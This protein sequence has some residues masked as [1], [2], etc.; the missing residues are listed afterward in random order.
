MNKKNSYLGLSLIIL[1]FAVIFIPRIHDR[2]VN[3]ATIENSRMSN[4]RTNYD[5]TSSR[6]EGDMI[7]ISKVPNFTF[8]N[9]DNDTI[10]QDY[11]KGKVYVVEF[12]FTSCSTICPVMNTNMKLVQEAFKNNDNV[13][14]ASFSID[15]T[16]DRPDVLT[17]YAKSYDVTH[18]NW[19]FLTGK[20]EDI[21]KLSNEGFKLY[22]QEN[23]EA[24]DGF[25]HSG[26]FALVDQEGNVQ[27]RIDENGNP[28][29]YYNGLEIETV[30]LLI[31]DIKK[32][33]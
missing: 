32:L 21:M 2:I 15:P 25:E 27:S 17:E 8:V 13:G 26:M 10:T 12:F 23:E 29:I 4:N 1:V 19:N 22:A 28:L 11:Y 14:I 9:Q 16:Y 5:E 7:V 31:E 30:N 6:S 24:E 18:P 20:K 3:G 33:L